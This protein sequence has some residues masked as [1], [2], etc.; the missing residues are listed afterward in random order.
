MDDEGHHQLPDRHRPKQR[1][2]C[3]QSSACWCL[4]CRSARRGMIAPKC[5]LPKLYVHMCQTV[6]VIR[7]VSAL[8]LELQTP[9]AFATYPCHSAIS[10]EVVSQ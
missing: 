8:F 4:T 9:S 1:T 7:S 3:P 2:P 10:L 6:H 5:Y